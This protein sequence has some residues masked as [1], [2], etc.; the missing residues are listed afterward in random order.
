MWRSK[1][2]AEVW[3]LAVTEE[4]EAKNLKGVRNA[5]Q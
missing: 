5:I 3:M 2:Y 4:V 1:D